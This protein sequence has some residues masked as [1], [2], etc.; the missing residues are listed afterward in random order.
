M[1]VYAGAVKLALLSDSKIEE[2]LEVLNAI[3]FALCS[4]CS[5]FR[6]GQRNMG[7]PHANAHTQTDFPCAGPSGGLRIFLDE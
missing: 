6:C 2:V 5:F 1:S 4:S 3:K 7:E